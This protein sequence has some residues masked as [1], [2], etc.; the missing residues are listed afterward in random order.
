MLSR[1]RTDNCQS[2]I[3]RSRALERTT[4]FAVEPDDKNGGKNYGDICHAQL[5]SSGMLADGWVATGSDA[6]SEDEQYCTIDGVRC[7]AIRLH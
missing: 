6:C 2:G 3:W 4:W 5:E 7:F 1:Y